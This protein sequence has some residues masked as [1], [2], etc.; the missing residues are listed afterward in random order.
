MFN[1]KLMSRK[2]YNLR[3]RASAA[4]D[5]GSAALH[6]RRITRSL[7]SS[8]AGQ[9]NQVDEMHSDVTGRNRRVVRAERASP[10][11]DVEWESDAMFR[12]VAQNRNRLQATATPPIDFSLEFST[13]HQTAIATNRW[14]IIAFVRERLEV[15]PP[16]L[17]L[18]RN[19]TF[20]RTL[21]RHSYVTELNA[22]KLEGLRMAN[23]YDVEEFPSMVVLDPRDLSEVYRFDRGI[24][25]NIDVF[26]NELNHFFTAYPTY[27]TRDDAVRARA[28][29]DSNHSPRDAA[30]LSS[31]ARK[32]QSTAF[33]NRSPKRGKRDDKD[34]TLLANEAGAM[35]MVDKDD[36]KNMIAPNGVPCVLRLRFPN[37]LGSRTETIEVNLNTKLAAVFAFI[38]AQGFSPSRHM[39]VLSFPRRQLTIKHKNRTLEEL[40]FTKSEM[41]HVEEIFA[42]GAAES[43]P[44]KGPNA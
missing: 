6:G 17:P 7:R 26:F 36:W 8:V 15:M 44:F 31:F 10:L 4:S 24:L 41:I 12:G 13:V 30:G 20:Q 32:R 25:A 33:L 23:N 18:L 35:S 39:F 27:E 37:D 42:D 43:A 3:E 14:L 2:G 1:Q 5:A 11:P 16:S 9:G 19:P 21:A 40:G 38:H 28:R 29:R 22:N 34:E